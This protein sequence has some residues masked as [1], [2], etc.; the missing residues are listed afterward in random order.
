MN[1]IQSPVL[2]TEKLP[3]PTSGRPPCAPVG[4]LCPL[5]LQWVSVAPRPPYAM[6]REILVIP[7]SAHSTLLSPFSPSE[8]SFLSLPTSL[9]PAPLWHLL[10]PLDISRWDPREDNAGLVN[11]GASSSSWVLVCGG[12]ELQCSLGSENS[13]RTS[14]WLLLG[15]LLF[16]RKMAPALPLALAG[17]WLQIFFRETPWWAR[18]WA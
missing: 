14:P 8:P 17:L 13:A 3:L 2:L 6:S 9:P 5:G 18:M 12:A 16:L 1:Q 15:Y 10:F 4:P 11:G 7:R